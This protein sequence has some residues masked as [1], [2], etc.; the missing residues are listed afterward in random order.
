[1]QHK[2]SLFNVI[3][4]GQNSQKTSQGIANETHRRD[5]GNKTVGRMHKNVG[6]RQQQAA[7]N[8]SQKQK[9]ERDF[10]PPSEIADLAHA[11]T[12]GMIR[13]VNFT[14]KKIQLP[15]ERIDQTFGLTRQL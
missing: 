11:K 3:E 13:T 2:I 9:I 14:K 8:D 15:W 5:S 1:L 6:A 12:N 7:N 10:D 4:K